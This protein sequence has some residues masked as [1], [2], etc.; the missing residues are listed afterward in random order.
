ME[1]TTFLGCRVCWVCHLHGT[2]HRFL[3]SKETHHSCHSTFSLRMGQDSIAIA[4]IAFFGFFRLGELLLESRTTYNSVLHL[5]WGDISI[6]SPINPSMVKVHLKKSKCDQ[7]G[8]GADVLL[9]VGRSGCQLCPVTAILAYIVYRH[10][11]LF[12]RGQPGETDFQSM[13]HS[14]SPGGLERIRLSG[15]SV[16]RTQHPHRGGNSGSLSRFGRFVYPD[17]RE[18]A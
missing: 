13:V 10:A 4:V 14:R 16:C 18:M 1:S 12:F 15:Q 2:N 6:H 11:W 17:S 3:S 5:S 8:A 9:H 7:F